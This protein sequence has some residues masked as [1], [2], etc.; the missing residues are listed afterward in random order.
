MSNEEQQ[1]K[2][3]ERQRG[4][5]GEMGVATAAL[6]IKQL[7][8]EACF[9]RVDAEDK[10]NPGRKVW[11]KNPDAP[12]LKQFARELKGE[13][14]DVAAQWFAHKK[15]SMDASRSDI[16]IKAAKEAAFATKTERHKKSAGNA[17]K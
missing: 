15:G 2:T 17:K 11:V 9:K 12:S 7:Y 4:D 8:H 3:P 10:H 5:R 16:N 14:M 13:S 1:E 6:T